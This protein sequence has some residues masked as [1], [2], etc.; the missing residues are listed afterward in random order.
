MSNEEQ[1][2]EDGAKR[3]ASGR[4]YKISGPN[5]FY[6]GSTG[7]D[8]TTRLS[9]HLSAYNKHIDNK[10]LYNQVFKDGGWD[11]TR[12]EEVEHVDSCLD[13][14]SFEETLRILE[15]KH[16]DAALEAAKESADGLPI[17]VN[18]SAARATLRGG[19]YQKKWRLDNPE[20]YRNYYQEN[21]E[22]ILERNRIK[23][24]CTNCGKMVRKYHMKRH[25]KTPRCQ[26]HGKTDSDTINRT[27]CSICGVSVQSHYL[28]R[29]QSTKRCLAAAA[30]KKPTHTPDPQSE[31]VD[32][33]T[34]ADIPFPPL[35]EE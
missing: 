19:E 31:V 24:A 26:N 11:Q 5:W 1:C 29:H 3:N 20:Y 22:K 28:K 32:I 35:P 30:L 12:V 14:H 18:R 17:L 16:I 13:G 15:Q 8:L 2:R 23:E 34:L 6:I 4:I 25:M 21:R 10:C 33:E 27:V 7:M 9:R